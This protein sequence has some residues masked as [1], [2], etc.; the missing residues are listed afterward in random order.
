MGQRL[1]LIMAVK[2]C[3]ARHKNQAKKNK[4]HINPTGVKC[5]PYNLIMY[6]YKVFASNYVIEN[7]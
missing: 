1:Y 7:D 4:G 3:F 5:N 6:A 2:K